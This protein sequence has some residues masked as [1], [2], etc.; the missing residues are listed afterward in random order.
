MKKE[1]I[2][3]GL[4]KKFDLKYLRFHKDDIILVSMPTKLQNLY[5]YAGVEGQL[6]NMQAQKDKIFEF[7]IL[8]KEENRFVLLRELEQ[9]IICEVNDFVPKNQTG[10]FEFKRP[11]FVAESQNAVSSIF[12]VPASDLEFGIPFNTLNQINKN[13]LKLQLQTYEKDYLA[14]QARQER[15]LLLNA[16]REFYRNF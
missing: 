1:E 14:E 12:S 2:N 5:G 10:E 3:M 7:A 9:K 15:L 4:K 11:P 8:N 13:C 6:R 16:C